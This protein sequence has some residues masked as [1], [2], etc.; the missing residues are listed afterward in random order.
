MNPNYG[1]PKKRWAALPPRPERQLWLGN[2]PLNYSHSDVRQRFVKQKYPKPA[3]AVLGDGANGTKYAIVTMH[4]AEDADTV[5]ARA[6]EKWSAFVWENG[7]FAVVRRS[8]GNVEW[9]PV[10]II[11]A[12]CH[13]R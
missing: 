3:H 13:C 12:N 1:Y 8:K 2:V 4:T 5:F 7:Q 11:L 10:L 9:A 6:R